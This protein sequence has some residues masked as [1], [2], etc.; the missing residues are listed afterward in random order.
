MMEKPNGGERNFVDRTRFLRWIVRGVALIGAVLLLWPVVRGM[1]LP[2]WVPA[3]SPFVAVSSLIATRALAVMVWVG[4]AVGV[5]VVLRPRWFCRWVCPV[6]LCADGATWLGRRLGRP[7]LRGPFWGQWI[8]LLTLGGALLGYPLLLW[9]DPLAIFAGAIHSGG[10]NTEYV[11]WIAA[12]VF[13]SVLLL[14][15]IW[16]NAWCGR[17]CPLGAFQDL[18]ASWKR[19][20]RPRS[21]RRE[22]ADSAGVA[23]GRSASSHQSASS[24]RRLHLTVSRRTALG[25]AAG[26]VGAAA[27]GRLRGAT[28]QPLRPPGAIDERNFGGVCTRCGNCLQVCP[29][30]IIERDVENGI[31]SLLTPVL[32][33]RKNYCLEDCALCTQ[34]CP[35]GA[36][37][38]LTPEDKLT[39]PMGIAKVD[40]NICVLRDDRE[41]NACRMRCPYGAIRY[42]F[43]EVDY[44]TRP[45]ID[46]ARCP[47]CGACEVACPTKPKKAIVVVP[48]EPAAA[49]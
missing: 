49:G 15:E 27:I 43:D 21:R 9:L 12:L 31:A 36:L 46:P 37:R 11:G 38:R 45:V 19:T 23:S 28:A 29:T 40:M 8:V 10:G 25:I 7:A 13:V 4:L 18:L 22:E 30:N 2:V 24:R 39:R 6:G 42:V 48:V 32:S 41:C 35:S 5:I 44:M 17:V 16:A 26:A 47:G 1:A 34:V 14:S 3:L 33:F 20:I